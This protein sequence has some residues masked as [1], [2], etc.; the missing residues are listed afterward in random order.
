MDI[1]IKDNETTYKME[2]FY[3][4]DTAKFIQYY[5]NV[6]FKCSKIEYHEKTGRVKY[7]LFEQL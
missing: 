7:L 3:N 1:Y 6:K 5:G 2:V 4:N